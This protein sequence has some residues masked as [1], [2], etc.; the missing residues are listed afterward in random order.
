MRTSAI[1]ATAASLMLC[2]ASPC[3]AQA[4]PNT[5]AMSC[6]AAAG[7]VSTRGAIVLGSGPMI[8]D[9]YVTDA[10]H[11]THD[12]ITMPAFVPAADVRECFIGYFCLPK[13]QDGPS[14]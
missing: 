1:K 2:A 13:I 7:L 9:R 10:G 14:H 11:C 3:F 12:E 4:R 8:Y 5:M 6:K